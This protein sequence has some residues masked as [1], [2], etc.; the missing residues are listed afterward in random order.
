V[1]V[2]DELFRVR[3][4]EQ[5]G[6][7]RPG[8]PSGRAL[9]VREVSAAPRR[10]SVSVTAAAVAVVRRPLARFRGL[11]IAV[12][13]KHYCYGLG[14]LTI[15]VLEVGAGLDHRR[16]EWVGVYGWPI[17]SVVLRGEPRTVLVRA[18]VLRLVLQR[19]AWQRQSP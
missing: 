12:P 4:D 19:A 7:A 6:P 18:S 14:E 15:Q 11:V 10:R 13:Q 17:H 1:L 9:S 8:H 5:T 16:A 3:H 2:A